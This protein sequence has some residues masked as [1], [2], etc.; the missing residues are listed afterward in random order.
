MGR[1]G[2]GRSI[3][4]AAL[5]LALAWA[6]GCDS[7]GGT[8]ERGTRDIAADTSEPAGDVVEG[9]ALVL[10]T[11]DGPTDTGD[12]PDEDAGPTEGDAVSGDTAGEGDAVGPPPEL[13][14]ERWGARLNGSIVDLRRLGRSLWIGTMAVPDPYEQRLLFRGELSRLDLDTGEVQVFEE[15]LPR[16]DYQ[17]VEPGVFA[18]GPVPT[19][20][21]LAL[22]DRTIV[23][24]FTGL[25]VPEGDTFV[26][27]GLPA[28]ADGPA[29]VLVTAS[30][31]ET[32]GRIWVSTVE[33]GLFLVDA[34][35]FESVAHYGT[36][37]LGTEEVGSVAVDPAS[38]AVFVA[39]YLPDVPTGVVVRIDPD[40]AAPD[41]LTVWTPGDGEA[42]TGVVQDIVWSE[43]RGTAYVALQSWDAHEGGVVRWDGQSAATVAVEGQ[44]A[45][46]GRGE[47]GAFG[48]S[49]LAL[50]DEH[51]VLV[52]G[53]RMRSDYATGLSGGGLAW[54][55]L[56]TG[57]LA[58]LPRDPAIPVPGD[59]VTALAY[60]P[61]TGRTYASLRYPCSELRLGNAGLFALSFREDGTV[62]VERPILSGVRSLAVVGEQLY[63]GL[64]DDAP[65]VACFDWQVQR[66]LV[67]PRSNRTGELVPIRVDAGTTVLPVDSGV[68]DLDV[69][70]DGRFVLGT[71]RDG[72]FV[73]P[74]DGGLG[75]NPTDW[76]PSLYVLDVAWD[77]PR[78][79]WVGGRS[80][81]VVGDAP[82]LADRG[83]RGVARIE[84]AEDGRSIVSVA[85]YARATS[86]P[87]DDAIPGLPSGEVTAIVP[88]EDGTWLVC[89][90]E[91]SWD[92]PLDRT[93]WPPYELEG[94]PRTGGVAFVGPDGAPVVV[95]G[96]EDVP[97]PRTAALDEDG[98]LLVWDS[99]RG[100]LRV[101]RADVTPV[102]LPDEVP[103]EVWPTSL[104]LGPDGAL[105]AT[106]S[107]G[108]LVRVAGAERWLDGDG[109]TWN[110]AARSGDVLLIAS[111]QGLLRVRPDTVPDVTEA[112]PGVA[113]RPPYA[114]VPPP[115]IDDPGECLP[116]GARCE[117]TGTPCCT[118]LE[119]GGAGYV[120]LCL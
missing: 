94:A 11:V 2:R 20:A 62:R 31:D 99:Q 102:E 27:H 101:T 42:P 45:A 76:G 87:E 23:V 58:G 66:G 88:T 40:A 91:G 92:S 51:G 4:V 18:D 30:A 24:A 46:A 59:H 22:G 54:I 52:V 107:R 109:W 8:D 26:V 75:E 60:D 86:Q 82:D 53:G 44:L 12:R 17:E 50:D 64:R 43:V 28:R 105:V 93:L 21:A 16:I 67:Q 116:A 73:G 39:T 112:P 72:L 98:S 48:A 10:D 74:L 6:S 69:A 89:G 9:D 110:A 63:A 70:P 61:E 5:A 81:H 96:P 84:L 85:H 80:M 106:S 7:P 113:A 36:A 108:A 15:Q 41:G 38:G 49:K 1:G 25:L 77:G 3:V 29:P 114:V 83:P 104:W 57:Q 14:V 118:G 119:C 90:T 78:H 79:V 111:D 120:T 56:A 115:E 34:D 95:A 71:W 47:P 33:D 19:A 97:D 35:T 100:L 65:G 32:R 68:V 55:E 117:L 13:V 37:E 103:A